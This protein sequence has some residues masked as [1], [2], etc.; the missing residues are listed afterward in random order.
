MTVLYLN[1]CYNKMCFKGLQCTLIANPYQ[2]HCLWAFFCFVSV[3]LGKHNGRSRISGKGV[4]MYK[5]VV[6]RFDDF[7]SFFPWKWNNLVSPRPN[8]FIFIG[9]LKWGAGRKVRANP[10]WTPSGSATEASVL[11]LIRVVIMFDLILYV[12]ST[13]FQLNRD[14][15]SWV[16]PI[17]SLD[18][19]VLPKDTMQWPSNPQPLSLESS[20]LPLSHCAPWCTTTIKNHT[21]LHL[22]IKNSIGFSHT[23]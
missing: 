14:W 9:Y 19:W 8:Y 3:L 16:E 23:Y 7:I 2:E 20:T 18:K 21:L 1:L 4:H 22:P 13:I 11:N 5:G 15:S 10:L 17:L 12:P 6:I